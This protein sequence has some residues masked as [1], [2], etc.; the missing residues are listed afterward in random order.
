MSTL[1][2]IKVLQ[3]YKVDIITSAMP[4]AKRDMI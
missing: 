4:L 1:A 2:I 3:G